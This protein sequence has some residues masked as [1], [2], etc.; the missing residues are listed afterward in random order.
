[1]QPDPNPTPYGAPEASL[2]GVPSGPVQAVT[3]PAGNGVNWVTDAWALFKKAP[4]MMIVLWII[5]MVIVTAANMVPLLGQLITPALM[6]GFML[7][8]AQ[9]EQAGELR[10][11]TLFEGFKSHAAPLLLL[12]AIFLLAIFVLVV[13]C[14]LFVAVALNAM[15]SGSGVGTVLGA[16][17]LILL[18]FT[19]IL[20]VVFAMWWAPCLVVFNQQTPVAALKQSIDAIFRNLLSSLVYTLVLLVL[21]LGVVVTLGLGILVVG[22]LV[23]VSAYTSY[24]DIFRPV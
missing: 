19:S 14:G 6:A 1:M 9:L 11:E 15:G 3:V 22:P 21:Y 24:K 7:A 2:Q 17:M 20:L 12:G 23:I 13:V 4:G 16:L 5:L 8:L 10:L 18:G